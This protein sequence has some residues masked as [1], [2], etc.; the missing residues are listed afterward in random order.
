[1]R[2][3]MLQLRPGQNPIP[4]PLTTQGETPMTRPTTRTN[5]I[6]AVVV[7]AI[8]S[9]GVAIYTTSTSTVSITSRTTRL[10]GSYETTG[11]TTA[12]TTIDLS[13]TL[14]TSAQSV[15]RSFI[16]STGVNSS[17]ATLTSISAESENHTC[18]AH[19]YNSSINTINAIYY[20]CSATLADNQSFKEF[21]IRS[22]QLNG[23]FDLCVNGSQAIQ[24][25]VTE[26]GTT[27]FSQSGTSVKYTGDA[28]TG[29]ILSV[30]ITNSE[31]SLTS[32]E[33]G[34]DWTSFGP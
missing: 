16:S 25:Q 34:L 19:N 31:A 9:I 30:T 14:D 2:Y 29:E 5:I 26:N 11:I 28:P 3:T 32:Y 20:E 7:I 17:T 12:R 13:T 23:T 8:A 24:V 4:N 33:L 6:V 18:V 21:I 10:T 22:S 27:I 1:M 15:T